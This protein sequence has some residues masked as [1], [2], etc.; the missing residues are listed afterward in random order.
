MQNQATNNVIFIK[1]WETNLSFSSKFTILIVMTPKPYMECIEVRGDYMT[2]LGSEERYHGT[3]VYSLFD[4][5]NNIYYPCEN[6]HVR[7]S[8]DGVIF[9]IYEGE[10]VGDDERVSKDI[11]YHYARWSDLKQ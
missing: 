3:R 5:K 7:A 1:K 10:P 11:V 9:D 6:Q 8:E 2:W 4:L